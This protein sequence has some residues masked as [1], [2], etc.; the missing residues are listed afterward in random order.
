MQPEIILCVDDDATVLNA[1]RTLLGKSLGSG[2]LLEIAESG[3]EALEICEEF[4]Q[5]QREVAIVISDFIMPSMRG[6]E[7]LIRIHQLS[8]RTVSMMLTGQSDLSGVERCIKEA[9]LFRFLEKPFQNVDIVQATRAA[10]DMYRQSSSMPSC[11][12]ASP[13]SQINHLPL[14]TAHST[15]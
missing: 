1:L 4:R 7:L 14:G 5:E 8:P 2:V 11:A 9:R 10:L 15:T 3:Q 13:N 6:D 12:S